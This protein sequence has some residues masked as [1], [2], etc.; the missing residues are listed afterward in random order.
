MKNIIDNCINPNYQNLVEETLR[1]DTDFRW[2]YHDNLVED[3]S[4]QLIGFSHMLL[5]DGKSTSDYTGLFLP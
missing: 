1:L 3:G 4:D 2:V 5:L